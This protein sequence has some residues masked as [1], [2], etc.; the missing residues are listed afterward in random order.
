MLSHFMNS[1]RHGPSRIRITASRSCPRLNRLPPRQLP[2]HIQQK[3]PVGFPHE[4]KQ[5]PELLPEEDFLASG[6]PLDLGRQF[7]LRKTRRSRAFLSFVEQL[8]EGGTH[9][10]TF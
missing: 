7:P 6:A 1:N 10:R 3:P 9:T 4:R 5:S 2:R 8:I